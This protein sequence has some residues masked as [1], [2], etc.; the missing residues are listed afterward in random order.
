MEE[1]RKYHN[2]VKRQLIRSVTKTG[3]SALDVGCGFGGDLQKW[4]SCYAKV[5]MCDPNPDSLIEARRRAENLEMSVTFYE[6]DIFSCPE[7]VYDVVCYNFSLHYIFASRELFFKSIKAIRSRMDKGSV[8]VGCI[9]DSMSILMATPFKDHMN[10]FMSRGETTGYGNF[11][12][13]VFVQLADTPFYKDGPK[14]EPIAYKD[15]LITHLEEIGIRLVLWESLE[16]YDISKLYSRF[17]F[18]CT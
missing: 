8:L 9:P 15:L 18:V 7:K 2:L 11:G 5:D 12:E 16:K 17:I 1:V 14:S 13:K 4:K 6:G 10:N 3:F